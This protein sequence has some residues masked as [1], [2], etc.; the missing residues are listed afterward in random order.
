M[1]ITNLVLRGISRAVS[2]INTPDGGTAELIN[3]VVENNEI[4]PISAPTPLNITIP[5]D[6][7]AIQVVEGGEKVFISATSQGGT[8]QSDTWIYFTHEE[9]GEKAAFHIVGKYSG[10]SATV[11]DNVVVI[12]AAFGMYYFLYRNGSYIELGQNPPFPKLSFGMRNEGMSLIEGDAFSAELDDNGVVT[13]SQRRQIYETLRGWMERS[14][15]SA[16]KRGLFQFPFFVRYALRLFDGSG[17]ILHSAPILMNPSTD[18]VPF[19]APATL[20]DGVGGLSGAKAWKLQLR[21]TESKLMLHS[22]A[23]AEDVEKLKNWKDLIS[24]IDIFV[25]QP[26]YSYKELTPDF[27]PFTAGEGFVD[28]DA[29]L[30]ESQ[31]RRRID[32]PNY[33]YY[34]GQDEHTAIYGK[35][36][37]EDTP[38]TWEFALPSF[39]QEEQYDKVKST[40]LFYRVCSIPIDELGTY[41]GSTWEDVP[42]EENALENLVTREVLRDDFNSHV[43]KRGGLTEVY[44]DRLILANMVFTPYGGYPLST[45]RS[46]TPVLTYGQPS[47]SAA[48]LAKGRKKI[49]VHSEEETLGN[50]S[51]PQ[52]SWWQYG[53]LY[54]PDPDAKEITIPAEYTDSE[55]EETLGYKTYSMTP[56]AALNGAYVFLGYP[57]RHIIPDGGEN[58]LPDL[59]TLE[60]DTY[61]SE[62]QAVYQ[63]VV[64]NPFQ[65]PLEGIT[66]IGSTPLIALTAS[67]IEVSTGQFGDFPMYAF[68]EDGVWVLSIDKEGWIS[69]PQ[70]I[71]NDVC[72][73]RSMVVALNRPVV[74]GSKRGLM[75]IEGSKI[76]CLSDNLLGPRSDT[77]LARIDETEFFGILDSAYSHESFIEF[78]SE[79][80]A[81]LAYDYA[82]NR[83]YITHPRALYCYV[84]SLQ[85]LEFSKMTLDSYIAGVIPHYS[86]V[87]LA[88]SSWGVN[89]GVSGVSKISTEVDTDGSGTRAQVVVVTRP[90]KFGT[91]GL[92]TIKHLLTRHNCEKGVGVLLYGSRDVGGD[93]SIGESAYGGYQLITSLRGRPYKYFILVLYAPEMT[94]QERISCV[95]FDWEQRFGNKFR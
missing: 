54:Y 94:P 61:Y 68:A 28:A 10:L 73:G 29:A 15:A 84:L 4:R 49:V 60:V 46:Y 7:L 71:S 2:D 86:G 47:Q 8:T 6:L 57:K 24:H 50:V 3:A 76:T 90:I 48:V 44:N 77:D 32:A 74:F 25:S 30:T 88:T 65:F 22:M 34:A 26:I 67:S 23:S 12:S 83:V 78:M 63:S 91:V 85:S 79:P 59:P 9:E 51:K 21:S 93:N 95:S 58:K 56:H 82:H 72:L 80:N 31:Y 5:G 87:Y 17:H 69:A 11:M 36:F 39:T 43:N 16:R 52:V 33:G 55:G 45:M 20:L 13:A 70:L 19:S 38:S 42:I 1:P 81:A 75:L 35:L 41:A 27:N 14:M 62:P 89:S 40:S 18:E 92:K 37:P 53:F 64:G 66:S